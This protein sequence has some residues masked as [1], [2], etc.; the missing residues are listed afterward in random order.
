MYVGPR[1][2]PRELARFGVATWA[3][4]MISMIVLL[5][6]GAGLAANRRPV[7]MAKMAIVSMITA[8]LAGTTFIVK[9][10]AMNDAMNE[11]VIDRDLWLYAAGVIAGLVTAIV[12]W[13][14]A[15][16]AS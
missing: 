1:A 8:A 13:R 4:A 6:L 5:A 2:V 12:A 10:M 9:V 14:R 16:S 15:S 3:A 7:L 11:A